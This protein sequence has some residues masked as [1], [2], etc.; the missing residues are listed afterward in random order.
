MRAQLFS[1]PAYT[2]TPLINLSPHLVPICVASAPHRNQHR[3]LRASLLQHGNGA[4][5]NGRVGAAGQAGRAES[6]DG[7]CLPAGLCP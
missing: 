2:D 3:G 5:Q 4:L 7:A 1:C 6:I